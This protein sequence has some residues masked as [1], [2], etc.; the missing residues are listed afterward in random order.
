[1]A[2]QVT[3]TA[4]V[5]IPTLPVFN[6]TTGQIEQAWYRFFLALWNRTGSGVGSL[7][8]PGGVDTNVQYN[9]AGSFGGLTNIQLTARIQPFTDVLKG[10]TPA[11]GGGTLNFLRADGAFAVPPGTATTPGGSSGNIQY[12]NAGAFGGLTDTQVTARINA[13]TSGLSGAV[14]LSGGGTTNFLR[15]DGTFAVPPGSGGSFAITPNAQTGTTY[16]VVNG[17]QGKV[18]TLS[19][20]AAV[21]VTLPQAG[22]GGLFAAGWAAF[23]TNKGAGLVT[24]TPT[25][26]TLDGLT[27]YYLNTNQSVGIASD[28]TNYQIISRQYQLSQGGRSI[29]LG[30]TSNTLNATAAA[31]NNVIAG[32]T[33]NSTGNATNQTIAGGGSNSTAANGAAVGGGNSNTASGQESAIPGGNG[34]VASGTRSF[35]AGFSSEATNTVAVSIGDNN[36]ASG[37]EACVLGHDS[38]ASGTDSVVLGLRA[39]DRSNMRTFA[40]SGGGPAATS[41]FPG[42][43]QW[44]EHIFWVITSGSAAVRLTADGASAASTNVGALSNSSSQLFTAEFLAANKTTGENQTFSFG[45]SLI[46]RAA[47]AA[48]TAMAA[49]NPAVTV[50][51]TTAAPSTLAANPTITADTTNG[52]YTVNVTPPA[53]NTNEWYFICK[54]N[55]LQAVYT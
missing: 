36:L 48:T 41:A 2:V 33:S 3:L 27:A 40:W 54:V 17:D 44:E 15:A 7:G 12:N 23:F 34:N 49:G 31:T 4:L 9:D 13:F 20:A 43:A 38:T 28:G 51:P 45:V 37:P 11:S 52:G 39:S 35:A 10:A 25:T 8:V 46:T 47:S 29:V 5:P 24:I 26:S 50:G 21:A 1:M 30:G 55:V 32:G 6:T 42:R 18:V 53:G 16:T 19:N 14:P 22:G